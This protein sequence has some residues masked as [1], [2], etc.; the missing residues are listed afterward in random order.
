MAFAAEWFD[1]NAFLRRVLLQPLKGEHRGQLV[2]EATNVRIG[3]RSAVKSMKYIQTANEWP[4]MI[5]RD[6]SVKL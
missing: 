4:I 1:N 5:A 6:S 3:G 2:L